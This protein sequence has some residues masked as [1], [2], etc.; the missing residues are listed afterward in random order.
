MGAVVV[1]CLKSW[2]MYLKHKPFV[3]E[4]MSYDISS[5]ISNKVIMLET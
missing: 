1:F 5:I 2:K 4:G 3:L